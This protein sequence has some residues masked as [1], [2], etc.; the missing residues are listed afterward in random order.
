MTKIRI[1]SK[2]DLPYI[3]E[4]Y[5]ASIS[6]RIA[7][8]DLDPISVESRLKWFAEHSSDRYPIW[9]MEMNNQ[10]T[11]W[12]SFQHFYGRPAYEKT[13]EISLY[14]SPYHQRQGIGKTLLQNGINQSKNLGIKTLLGFIFAHNIPSLDLFKKHQF[15]K[16]GYLQK[17]AYLDGIERDLVI[18]GRTL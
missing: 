2:E 18:V 14:V 4:I 10:I 13:V 7:T 6:S 12:L 16:W 1:A 15:E 8:G 5:N 9:V 11:G 17:V 3:V